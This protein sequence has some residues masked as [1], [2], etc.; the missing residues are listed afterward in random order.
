MADE[1]RAREVGTR[2]PENPG[3]PS[4]QLGARAPRRSY[5]SPKLQYL[6]TVAELTFGAGGSQG[7][8]GTVGTHIHKVG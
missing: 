5:V 1:T 8:G 6:G 7:D 3:A 4:V 2:A